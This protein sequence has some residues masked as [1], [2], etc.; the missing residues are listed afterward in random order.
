MI[1]DS[2][3]NANR[4]NAAHSTGPRTG[5]GKASSSRNALT[6][7]L[8]TRCD[9][10]KPEERDIYK[11]FCETMYGELNPASLLEESFVSEITGATWRLRRCSAAEGDLADY[12]TQDPLLDESTDKQRRSI[13]RARAAAHSIL[14][15]SINQLRKLQT[16]RTAREQL[17]PIAPP[18]A[19]ADS[20]KVAQAANQHIR[21]LNRAEEAKTDAFIASVEAALA[22]I[23][24][25]P[26][27]DWAAIDLSIAQ[28][29]EAEAQAAK[30]AS[31]CKPAQTATQP[32]PLQPANA[33][34]NDPK[35]SF[36]TR[37]DRPEAA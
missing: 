23:M 34:T 24:N 37:P 7:G 5:A 10:V 15:R 4:L 33:M 18:P 16:E 8:Y 26:E 31:I 21:D 11:E 12:A 19:L 36:R 22:S 14:H 20:R 1:T 28:E 30:L 3:L 25:C 9:Y 2:R 6:L 13:E 29:R 27:P 32:A 35:N 17:Q